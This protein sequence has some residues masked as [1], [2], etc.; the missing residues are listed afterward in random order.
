MKQ[1]QLEIFPLKRGEHQASNKFLHQRKS[2]AINSVIASIVSR[3]FRLFQSHLQLN[4]NKRQVVKGNCYCYR[5]IQLRVNFNYEFVFLYFP[6]K[7]TLKSLRWP[8]VI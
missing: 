7:L 8:F 6:G 1:T 4:L 5:F 2:T 3:D